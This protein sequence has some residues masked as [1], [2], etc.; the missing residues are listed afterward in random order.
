VDLL[1]AR[2]RWVESNILRPAVTSNPRVETFLDFADV[3]G[4]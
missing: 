4:R 2:E 3:G 1:T